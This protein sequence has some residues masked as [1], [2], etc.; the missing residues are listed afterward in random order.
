[1][2]C[3]E[4]PSYNGLCTPSGKKAYKNMLLLL[5]LAVKQYKAAYDERTPL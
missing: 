3:A 1:M 2:L 4:I 5:L